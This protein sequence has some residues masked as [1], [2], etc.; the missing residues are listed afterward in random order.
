MVSID[1]HSSDKFSDQAMEGIE[2]VYQKDGA[3]RK[4]ELMEQVINYDSKQSD[5]N[6]IS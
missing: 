6:L 2:K 3:M 4:E 1:D 5:T